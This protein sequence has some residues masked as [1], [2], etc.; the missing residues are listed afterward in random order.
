MSA[1]SLHPLHGIHWREI[2][3]LL[4]Y[5][6]AHENVHA[7]EPSESLPAGNIAP[8]RTCAACMASEKLRH[9]NPTAQIHS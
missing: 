7:E 9:D 3:T 1:I 2:K 6:T 5:F 4:F 8:L